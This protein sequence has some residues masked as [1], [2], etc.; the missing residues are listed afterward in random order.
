MYGQQYTSAWINS[1]GLVTFK[2]PMYYGWIGS[3]PNELPTPAAE[4]QPDAAVYAH[5]DDWVLDTQSKIAT[6]TTGTAPNRKWVVEWRNVYLYGDT[7]ARATFES[8]FSENGDITIAYSSIDPN[9][10]VERG[11][12]ATVG[13][14]NA[15]GSIGFQYLHNAALLASGQGVMFKPTQPGPGV[16]SGTLT[17][18]GAPVAGASVAV[19]G[20]SATTSANGTYQVADVPAGTYAVIATQPAGECR[21]SAVDRVSV[22]THTEVTADF[23]TATTA[24]SSGYTIAEQPIA[25][26]PAD[27]AVLPITGDDAYAPVNL[28]FPVTHYGNTYSTA[29]VDANGLLAFTDPGESSSDAWPIPSLRSPEEPNNAIY[30]F[31]HDW[32]IDDK[33]S[34]R[35]ATRGTA[36]QRQYVVEWRNVASYED[37]NTR[38]SFQ[39]IMDEAGGYS[40]AYTEIDGTFLELGGGATIG[41]ENEQGT[42]ALEY[43]YREPVLRPGLGLRITPPTS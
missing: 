25:W 32:I 26:A 43:T 8:V 34:V 24:P 3:T 30:P 7:S 41:I 17:C 6:A 27:G 22:G 31:W 1:N 19:A 35:S 13:I 39:L 40:F 15:A 38:V 36:P 12:G 2:D 37:P 42:A 9:N 10:A 16:V 28:P 20:K 23:L 11:S 5:W 29:W 18:Q 4:G 14:E 33:A 21:G